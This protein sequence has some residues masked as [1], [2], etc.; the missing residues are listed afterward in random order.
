MTT[1]TAS[2]GTIAG[3]SF[4]EPTFRRNLIK[5]FEHLAQLRTMEQQFTKRVDQS[6]YLLMPQ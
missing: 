5:F 4:M 3:N 6:E 1:A 2:S